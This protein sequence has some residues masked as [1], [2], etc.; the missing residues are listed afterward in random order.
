MATVPDYK[1]LAYSEEPLDLLKIAKTIK[2]DNS[3]LEKLL[4]IHMEK[5]SWMKAPVLTIDTCFEKKEYLMRLKFLENENIDK[6]IANVVNAR[7]NNDLEY[8]KII[9]ENKFSDRTLKLAKALRD[10]IFL[11]TYTTEYSDRLFYIGRHTIFKEIS[12]KTDIKK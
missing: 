1:P 3:N 5:Y 8:E 12:N 10:F 11:R 9:K 2:E 4:D 7:K 6:K